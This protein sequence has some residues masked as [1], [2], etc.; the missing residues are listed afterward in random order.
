[1]SVIF[2]GDVSL[3]TFASNKIHAVEKH[4]RFSWQRQQ[5]CGHCGL[6]LNRRLLTKWSTSEE[7]DSGLYEGQRRTLWTLAV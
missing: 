4:L 3:S 2:D 6:T 7:N 5:T 1:M